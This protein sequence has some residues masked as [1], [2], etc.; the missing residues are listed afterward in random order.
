[1]GCLGRGGAGAG[2]TEPW[3]PL[4]CLVPLREGEL[5][6]AS[7]PDTGSLPGQRFARVFRR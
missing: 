3:P 4:G 7:G 5:F 2:E 6:P 1:G